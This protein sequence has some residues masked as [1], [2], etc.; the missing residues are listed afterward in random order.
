ME[1]LSETGLQVRKSNRRVVPFV[2]DSIRTNIRKAAVRHFSPN[3]L[4][5]LVDLVCQ[6]SIRCRRRDRS[7]PA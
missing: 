7:R 3:E 1:Q 2:R 4:D 5:E 6:I